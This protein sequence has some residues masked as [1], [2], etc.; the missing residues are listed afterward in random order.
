MLKSEMAEAQSGTI[1]I[2]D[3]GYDAVLEMVRY[4]VC[5]KCHFTEVSTQF[6]FSLP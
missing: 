1:T 3:F 4:L 6:Q 5:G 2:D